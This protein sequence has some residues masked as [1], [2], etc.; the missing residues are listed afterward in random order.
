MGDLVTNDGDRSA[1]AR[2]DLVSRRDVIAL[3]RRELLDSR[4]PSTPGGRELHDIERG[5]DLGWRSG[6]NARAT[7]LIATLEQGSVMA[8]LRELRDAMPTAMIAT[9]VANGMLFD[10]EGG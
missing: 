6:W 8:G 10:G 5:L 3:L 4:H 2:P 9:S 1:Q 7:S